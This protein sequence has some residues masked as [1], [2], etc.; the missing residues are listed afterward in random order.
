MVRK[1]SGTRPEVLKQRKN[2]KEPF[3]IGR[4][5][6]RNFKIMAKFTCESEFLN[7]S[8]K[9]Y[10][11]YITGERQL[12]ALIAETNANRDISQEAKTR[13]TMKMQE[14]IGAKRAGMKIKMDELEKEFSDWAY[15]FAD[16]QGV[17]LSK[18][19]VQ[20]L[21]SGISYSPQELLYLA[22]KNKDGEA[23]LRLISDYAKKQG[24]EMNCY[25]S[26]EQKIKDFHTMNEIFGKSADDEDFKNWVRLPDSEVD[27]FVNKRLNTIC[28]LPED[29]T[30]KEIPKTI[31]ESIERDIIENRK[32]EVEN[33]DKNGEFLEGFGQE[34]PKVDTEFFDTEDDE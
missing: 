32:K 31:D 20:A 19:L 15:D 13:D 26:P 29:F 16:L 33:C 7:E 10:N 17:G 4:L 6:E 12:K 24:F 34:A 28:I 3:K 30:I 5:K 8:K 21:N 9:L 1:S 22:K 25:R 23:D 11:K 27:D 14:D 18:N 2:K